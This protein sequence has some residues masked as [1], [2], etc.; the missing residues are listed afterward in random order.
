MTATVESFIVR[1]A[2]DKAMAAAQL[3]AKH[4]QTDTSVAVMGVPVALL[5]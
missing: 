3:Q 2:H 5:G 4:S 1:A